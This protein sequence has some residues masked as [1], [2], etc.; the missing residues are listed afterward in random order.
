MLGGSDGANP[1]DGERHQPD[2]GEDADHGA[3]PPFVRVGE[4]QQRVEQHQ[5]GDQ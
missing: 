1:S 4:R 2:D 5:R 3:D